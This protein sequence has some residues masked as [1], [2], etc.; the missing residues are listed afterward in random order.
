LY[1][2]ADLVG[3]FFWRRRTGLR[4]RGQGIEVC[5]NWVDGYSLVNTR[6]GKTKMKQS[7]R[8]RINSGRGESGMTTKMMAVTR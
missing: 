6:D 1:K 5:G 3:S 4:S 7:T 8:Q 2:A